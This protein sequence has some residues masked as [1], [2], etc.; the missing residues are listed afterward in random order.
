VPVLAALFHLLPR[1]LGDQA[2]PSDWAKLRSCLS[3]RGVVLATG[4]FPRN[5]DLLKELAPKFPHDQ[6]VS[7]Q[8]NVGD[9]MVQARRLGA[10]ADNAMCGP[11]L[12]TPTSKL[13]Q[14][15]GTARTVLYGY[16]DRG[17]PGMIAVDARG[18][19]FVNESNSYHHIV[20]GMFD[21]GVDADSRFYQVW[22]R[23]FLWRRGRSGAFRSAEATKGED[24][25]PGRG[26]EAVLRER[27]RPGSLPGPGEMA[28]E[29]DREEGHR[30]GLG[31]GIARLRP[32][33]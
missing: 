4:G 18:Q 21:R 28:T 11:C 7:F 26:G 8:G 23:R 33:Q 17:R 5:P 27:P 31:P 1:N 12:W 2:E 15:D 29:L 10:V 16:L 22:D 13:H 20:A 19:R 6:T 30:R 24:V 25:L 14:P 3:R 9:A 32:L